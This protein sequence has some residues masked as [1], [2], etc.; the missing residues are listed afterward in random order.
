MLEGERERERER[1][2][3]GKQWEA[4]API[5]SLVKLQPNKNYVILNV[6]ELACFPCTWGEHA[7]C[8]GEHATM[9]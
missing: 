1:V 8:H 9:K 2:G 4:T 5:Q 7:T 6:G 3:W